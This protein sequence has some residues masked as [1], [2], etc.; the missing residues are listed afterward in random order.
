MASASAKTLAIS[1]SVTIPFPPRMLRPRATLS[2]IRAV[3][4]ALASAD[5]SSFASPASSSWE[6]L[7]IMPM[8]LTALP[9][10]C[11]SWCWISW[12][13]AIGRPNWLRSTA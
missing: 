9:R 4:N 8:E 2:R 10:I 1:K 3:V 6:S 12:K 7:T 11:T 5:C 13:E